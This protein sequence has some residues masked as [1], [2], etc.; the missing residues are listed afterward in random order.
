MRS[1]K[2]VGTLVLL[3]SVL[4]F[5]VVNFHIVAT[6]IFL[7]KNHRCLVC[8][9]HHFIF[10]EKFWVL[11][12]CCHFFLLR[13]KVVHH[14]ST[15][16]KSLSCFWCCLKKTLD[17]FLKTINVKSTLGCLLPIRTSKNWKE[18][19]LLRSYKYLGQIW[20]FQPCGLG[21]YLLFI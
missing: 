8:F 5:L 12:S 6:R 15:T 10:K 13:P 21:F 9:S 19:T 16:S 4:F 1:S 2:L 18:K 17:N 14:F 11:K 7:I 3:R 20:D